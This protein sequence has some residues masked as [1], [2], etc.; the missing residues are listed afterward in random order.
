MAFN[1]SQLFPNDFLL[2]DFSFFDFENHSLVQFYH[3]NMVYFISIY[4]F[5]LTYLTFKNKSQILYKP[6]FILLFFLL[7][8]IILGIFTLL[9]D[10][11][12]LLASLHQI[13]SVIL[14]LSAL[15]LY[16]SVIK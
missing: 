9:S 4:I 14:V 2:R 5:I 11:N 16:Y 8:Q 1:G 7:L 6:I 13:I 12:I 15:N 10:L 3:R